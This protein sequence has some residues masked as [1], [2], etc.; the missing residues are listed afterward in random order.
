MYK[1]NTPLLGPIKTYVYATPKQARILNGLASFISIW[2]IG[3]LILD[4]IGI[5]DG[6]SVLLEFSRFTSY[7]S[8]SAMFIW[9]YS[10]VRG[11][12][13]AMSTTDHIPEVRNSIGLGFIVLSFYALILFVIILIIKILIYH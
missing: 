5:Y 10:W 12:Q 3:S 9:F 7:S 11:N 13:R 1:L 8:A 4:T 2:Y 6:E